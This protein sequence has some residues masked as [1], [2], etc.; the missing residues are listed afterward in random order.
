MV[1]YSD[2]EIVAFIGERKPLSDDYR[3]RVQLKNKRGHRERELD[4]Q[5][6]DG[7]DYRLILRQR[8]FNPLDFSIILTVFPKDTTQLFRLCRYNGKSHE[9]TN[10]IENKTFYDFHIHK[11]TERY[12]DLGTREDAF[13]EQSDRFADFQ[14]ALRCMLDDCGFDMPE[15]PQLPLFEEMEP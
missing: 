5:G 8:D 13:A 15:G 2:Q 1:K 9:H 11:A 14:S 3:T 7:N 6:A 12:Q 4:V 10:H